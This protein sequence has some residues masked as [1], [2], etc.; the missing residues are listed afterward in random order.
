LDN[1]YQPPLTPEVGYEADFATKPRPTVVTVFGILNLVFGIMGM[2]CTPFSLLVLLIPQP[3][4]AP[5][6]PALDLMKSPGYAQGLP[7]MVAV[8]MLTSLLLTI[9]GV[10]LLKVR[11]WGR[12]LSNLYV[13]AFVVTAIGN[14]A[15]NYMNLYAPLL[16][17]ARKANDPQALTAATMQLIIGIGGLCV[18]AIYPLLL[19]IFMNRPKVIEALRQSDARNSRGG[20]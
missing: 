19:A 20:S 13:G 11:G 16:E 14:L 18:G 2:I 7:I 10:G 17:Q 8:G 4:N 5:P 15:F 6:N 12:S 9:A 1:P 3:P